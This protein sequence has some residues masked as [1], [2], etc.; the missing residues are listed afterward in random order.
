MA[1][2]ILLQHNGGHDVLPGT[3]VRSARE[4]A[5]RGAMETWHLLAGWLLVFETGTLKRFILSSDE[6]GY[7]QQICIPKSLSPKSGYFPYCC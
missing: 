6:L 4:G 5:A 1:T 2:L 3:S 7:A